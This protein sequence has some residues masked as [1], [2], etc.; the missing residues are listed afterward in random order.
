MSQQQNPK[1]RTIEGTLKGESQK[2]RNVQKHIL[3]DPYT[4]TTW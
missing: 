2:R 3:D 1:K 4:K